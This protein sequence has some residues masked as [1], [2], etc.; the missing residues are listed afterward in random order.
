M[1]DYKYRL[2]RSDKTIIAETDDDIATMKS[3]IHDELTTN[4]IAQRPA[5]AQIAY[6]FELAARTPG[7]DYYINAGNEVFTLRTLPITPI[8]TTQDEIHC[9]TF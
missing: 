9:Q 8:T 6:A 2:I 1:T 4:G 5:W 3:A 7:R